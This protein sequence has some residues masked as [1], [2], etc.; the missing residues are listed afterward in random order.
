MGEHDRSARREDAPIPGLLGC[1]RPI[2]RVAGIEEFGDGV[3]VLEVPDPRAPRTGEVL[4]EVKAAGVGN[5]DEFARTGRWDLGRGPPMALGVAAAGVV[6]AL[7]AGFEGWSVGDPVFTHP[8]P[9]AEQGCWAPWLVAEAALLAPKPAELSWTHAAS[10][11]VPALTAVQ[12]L[13]EG[14]RVNRGE[15]LLVNGAGGATGALIVSMAALRGVEV[16]ATAGPRSR[17]RV[18]GS[19]AA[20]VIDYHDPDWTAQVVAATAG[21][22]VDAAANAA[23]DGAA[24]ALAAVRDGGRLVTITSDPPESERGIEVVSLY[25]RAD[26]EQLAGAG[27]CARRRGAARGRRSRFGRRTARLRARRVFPPRGGRRGTRSRRCRRRSRCARG[28]APS[29][30]SGNTRRAPLARNARSRSPSPL[31]VTFPNTGPAE[32]VDGRSVPDGWVGHELPDFL[33]AAAGTGGLG[34]PGQ[35]VLA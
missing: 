5:W 29:A 6:A 21:H 34:S 3:T 32:Y 10:F 9:L 30:P 14:L 18:I 19:G 26:G 7:G 24:V 28:L 20:T 33:R 11:P 22:G 16:I 35:R 2:V 23:P 27:L 12:V 13:D 8:L 4:I 1:R 17:E 15:R 31:R 25:V